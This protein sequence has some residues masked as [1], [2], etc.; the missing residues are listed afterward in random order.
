MDSTISV[1]ANLTSKE[2][3]PLYPPI[4][5]WAV[6][7]TKISDVEIYRSVTGFVPV[8]ALR[9]KDNVCKYYLDFLLDMKNHQNLS[10]I[11]FHSDQD[12]FSKLSQMFWKEKKCDSVANK[13]G[14]FILCW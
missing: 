9:P 3:S 2:G 4:G 11:F 6:F 7:N 1:A 13:W 5:S 14:D 8:I 10:Y 12:V